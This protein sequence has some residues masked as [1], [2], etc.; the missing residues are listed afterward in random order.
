MNKKLNIYLKL[1]CMVSILLLLIEC[2][3]SKI[4]TWMLGYERGKAELV[5]KTI[6]LSEGKIEYMTNTIVPQK[7]TILMIHGFGGD[8]D[9]WTFFAKYLSRDYNLIVLD[10]PG[11]GKSFNDIS[12]NYKIETQAQRV[13]EFL[14]K[15]NINKVHLIGHSM[16][17]AISLRFSFQYPDRLLSLTV[18]N[19]G[20]AHAA[21]SEMDELLKKGENPLLVRSYEDYKRLLSFAMEKQPYVPDAVI[22]SMA[23]EKIP[24]FKLEQKI[25]NEIF[26]FMDQIPILPEIH[27]P[28]LIIWGENDRIIHKESAKLI[29]QKIEGSKLSIIPG[30]GHSPMIE[31]P[32]GTSKI[33]LNFLKGLQ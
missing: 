23:D 6:D 27:A 1:F 25:F 14:Q 13:N 24:R 4:Y 11:F 7:Q 32:E 12:L 17:G 29:N 2:S 21:E 28:T 33:Y 5:V 22:K 3:G 30:L 8:K 26:H 31:D 10:L 20:G 15:L 16:G 19:A 9:N 18:V